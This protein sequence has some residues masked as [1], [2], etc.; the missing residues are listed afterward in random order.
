MTETIDLSLSRRRLLQAGA[1]VSVTLL[2]LDALGGAALASPSVPADL[3]RATF[4]SLV[5]QSVGSAAGGLTLD[6]VADVASAA[7]AGRDDVF[8]LR[9]SGSASPALRQGVQALS[10]PQ[11]GSFSLFLVPVD[12]TTDRQRYEVT[13]DRSVTL[14]TALN[15]APDPLTDR[16]GAA[17]P[18]TP[19]APPTTP[20]A[21]ATAPSAAPAA[22]VSSSGGAVKPVVALVVSVH[23]AR[24]GGRLGV[25]LRLVPSRRI[26]AVRVT[27]LRNG[28]TLAHG[29]QQLDGR[30]AV[31]V[32]LRE[33]RLVAAGSYE[34]VI[35][36]TDRLG[37]HTSVRRR[38]TLA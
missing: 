26:T 21:P 17:P 27:L 3:R 10:H 24:R 7:L 8:V 18:A 23:L 14:A 19:A 13:V 35:T 36:T 5:G 4:A 2:G 28:R 37:R 38:A 6:E 20:A 15:A 12:E 16:P 9:L 11:L 29:S 25:D 22:A 34:L 1:A 30:H 32:A 33:P 31:R